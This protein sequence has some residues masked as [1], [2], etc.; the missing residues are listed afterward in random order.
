MLLDVIMPDLN[1]FQMLDTILDDEQLRNIPV[2]LL[3]ASD[4]PPDSDV[5]ITGAI[6]I[7]N[8]LGFRAGEIVHL[9]G[10]IL[11]DLTAPRSR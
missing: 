9:L 11:D 2:I 4:R 3:A 7:Q 10:R 5:M 8:A 1:G 6:Q